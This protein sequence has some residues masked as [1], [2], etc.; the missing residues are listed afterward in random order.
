MC[1]HGGTTTM[2][3]AL[4]LLEHSKFSAMYSIIGN[5][6]LRNDEDLHAPGHWGELF[7]VYASI[8]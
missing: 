5:I 2:R 3:L 7:V 4:L 8:E 6:G 1:E